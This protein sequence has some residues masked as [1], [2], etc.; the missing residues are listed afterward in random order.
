MLIS[1]TQMQNIVDEMKKT[2]HK[3]INIMDET[4]CII[5][6]TD[7]S[8]IGMYH[9]GAQTIISQKLDELVIC[10]DDLY[11]GA[12]NGINLPIV[13]DHEIVGVVGITGEKDEVAE[14]GKIIQ[15]MAEIM[16]LD[17]YQRNY[18]QT[19]RDMRNNFVFNWLF[20]NRED[21]DTDEE[22][23]ISG[24]LLGIDVELPRVV[25]I[26]NILYQDNGKKRDDR[27]LQLQ[28]LY[29]GIIREIDHSIGKDEQ[30]IVLQIGS[31]IIIFFHNDCSDQVVKKVDAIARSI[32]RHYGCTVYGGIGTLGSDKNEIRRSY[33]EANMA[34]DM[35]L[36]IKNKRIKVYSDIDME[37]LLQIIPKEER[38]SFFKKVLKNCLGEELSSWM[39]LL[40]CFVENNGSITQ[41]ADTLFIHKN[42]LQYR[43]N[44]L[45]CLT[46]YDPRNIKEAVPL[47]ISILIY[48]MDV[49]NMKL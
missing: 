31:K 24:S 47:Y 45:K 30:Q 9:F 28:R 33:R 7:I 13:I 26:L 44:K 40:R 3:N 16:I 5:A 37:M 20:D 25:T 48:E 1:K 35:A 39:Q 19:T 27:S 6:S 32:E 18:R 29:D 46:D 8:R 38:I 17:R 42:T 2:L 34:C 23:K 12:R 41:T 36:K 15:K 49:E 10:E 43:L 14:F 21:G 4:G 22:L 11:E